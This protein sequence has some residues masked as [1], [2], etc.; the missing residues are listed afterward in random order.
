MRLVGRNDAFLL[1]GLAVALFVVFA[2]PLGQALTIAQDIDQRRGLRLLPAL[3]ILAGVLIVHL[4]R[5]RRQMRLEARAATARADEL[6]QLVAF[7]QALA[8][9]LEVGAIRSAAVETLPRLAP[10][11]VV[12]VMIRR[13]HQWVPMLGPGEGLAARERAASRALGELQ[14]DLDEHPGDVCFPMIVAGVPLGVLGVSPTPPLTAQEKS[15]LVGAAALLGVSIKNAELFAEVQEASARD[16]LTTCFTRKHALDVIDG[17]LRR[18]R[19]TNDAVTLVMFDI[20][21]FKKINDRFGHLGG[22]AVL[23]SVGQRM[24]AVLRASDVKCRYGGDEFLVLLPDT[25]M[26]GARRVAET[27]RHELEGRPVRWHESAI[28]V[29]ASFGVAEMRAD[30]VEVEGL[31]GRADAAL[32]RAKQGGRNRIEIADPAPTA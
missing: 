7:G 25:P 31:V 17:E 28:V 6:E 10:G 11:R 13:A 32:Y 14:V 12:W 15:G 22:D 23:A 21:Q 9:S 26:S 29:T 5:R 2:R 1:G 3:V 19:R 18:A 30:D 20:D 16:P 8:R 4:A 27:L 24:S